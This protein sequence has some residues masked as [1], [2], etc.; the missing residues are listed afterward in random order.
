MSELRNLMMVAANGGADPVPEGWQIDTGALTTGD[1]IIS[2]IRL[3]MTD[4][5]SVTPGH[6]IRVCFGANGL[7]GNTF[8]AFEYD[9]EKN[10]LDYWPVNLSGDTR[11]FTAKANTAYVNAV[12]NYYN[13][14]DVYIRDDTTGE[15]LYKGKNVQ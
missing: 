10:K 4:F 6:A 14:D 8:L 12:V 11:K 7:I 13:I 1:N 2:N 15:Y 3:V 9:S 5:Y